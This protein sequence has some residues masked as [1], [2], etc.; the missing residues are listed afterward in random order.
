MLLKKPFMVTLACGSAAPCGER[1]RDPPTRRLVGVVL[2]EANCPPPQDSLRHGR[3]VLHTAADFFPDC[4]LRMGVRLTAGGR[5][6][7]FRVGL[8]GGRRG[9]PEPHGAV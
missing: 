1:I 4:R 6:A 8:S 3:E 5:K 2:A 7:L 9:A